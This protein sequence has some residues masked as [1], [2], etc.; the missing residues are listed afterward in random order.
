M[1]D[2]DKI[3]EIYQVPEK[4][5]GLV[6]G[7]GGSEIR[8]IQQTSGCRVQMDPDHQSMNGIRNC[9]I[10]G[11][12]D[13][14]AIAKQMITQV[15]S[16]N[17]TG[18]PQTVATGEVTE[19]MLIPADKI[20]LVIGKGGDTIRTLQDQSGLR[21][22]NVVQDSSSATGQPKPLR[23]VGTP[24]AIE[25]A[26]ALVHNIMNSSPGNPPLL[27]R[28]GQSSGGQYGG[29]GGQEAKG[30]VIVPRVSAGMIIG[31]GGEMIKRLAMETGTKIQFKPDA[32]PNSEDRVAVIMGTR[33]QIYRATERIT[34]IVNRAIKNGQAGSGSILG[35]NNILGQSTFYMHVP[36]TKCGLVIGKGGE[37]IKQI[38][39]DSG[40][41]CGLA[42]ASEQKN[43]DE[44]V[45]EIKGTQYQI[46][47]ASHLVKIK[48]GEI[49]PNTPVP[50]LPGSGYQQH[51]QG[52][53]GSAAQS[54]GYPTGVQGGFIQQQQP[55]TQQYGIPQQQQWAPSNGNGAQ[56]HVS[57]DMYHNTIQ[58]SHAVPATV[59]IPQ[60]STDPTPAV[61]PSTGAPD[62][63]AQWAAYY[64]SIGLV[65][66]A[67]MVE[68]Q[69]RRNQATGGPTGDV[70][71]AQQG[72]QAYYSQ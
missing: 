69:M 34:E 35:G 48:V 17:Q 5:V 50:P 62:Y 55:Q 18:V 47:H 2:T 27:P 16:R 41:S 19:E 3:I 63:S 53:Y 8:L 37:N 64:R 39:R 6:I 11:P 56:Q 40:A 59:V 45:F 42:A 26:K 54:G 10:E 25:T 20:G 24:A 51:P 70:P 68:N 67:A 38:E 49:A 65:E 58:Q 4:V 57:N 15:I 30:E 7:K 60:G 33:D 13:Q 9:T 36:A 61:N 29:Y 23:M 52:M 43:E 12:P 71:G 21:S 46:H 1:G 44:K 66:Q 31:K 22:L 14:V 72:H 32:N 28:G